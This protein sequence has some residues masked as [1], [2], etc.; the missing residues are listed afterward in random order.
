MTQRDSRIR[1]LGRIAPGLL[2]VALLG[3]GSGPAGALEYGSEVCADVEAYASKLGKAER[4]RREEE[5]RQQ[6]LTKLARRVLIESLE[7]L[8]EPIP[9]EDTVESL[10]M[11]YGVT[12]RLED[13]EFRPEGDKNQKRIS[14]CIRRDR[15]ES[16]RR[17]LVRQR[18]R[19]ITETR[20]RLAEVEESIVQGDLESASAALTALEIEVVAEDLDLAPYRSEIDGRT[21]PF[22]VWLFEWDD[23]VTRGP[24]FVKAMTDR[25]TD[26]IELGR[27]E[28][29]DRYVAEALK[30]DRQDAVARELRDTIQERRNRRVDLLGEAEEMA[31]RG[32]F[33]AA[34]LNLD[35]ARSMGSDDPLPLEETAGSINALHAEYL[36]YNPKVGVLA[37]MAV[38]TLGV[39]TNEIERRVLS[40]TGFASE[41][42]AVLGVGAAGNFRLGRFLMVGVTGSWGLSQDD[43]RFS[44]G[45]TQEL[46]EVYQLT[47]GVGYRTRRHEKRKVSFQLTG[48]P[49]LESVKVST[50]GPSSVSTSDSQIALFVRLAAEWPHGAFFVQHGLGFDD[51]T[52]SL[53]GWSNRLQLG[54]AIVF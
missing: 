51:N 31:K 13:G 40:E 39:D 50:N 22:Y 35:E 9:T 24:E 38:G 45:E 10:R 17:D 18:E 14:Y 53:V 11:R 54:A 1:P 41:G 27:L 20:E 28:E 7:Q 5:A 49:V 43:A 19:T 42:S 26:L 12:E 34:R 33:T 2:G 52:D 21:R 3:L 15:Y 48:G 44:A 47:A 46:Y 30:A 23:V 6:A 4:K 8:S 16:V 37:Y 32:R 25:A 29:A 36:Q